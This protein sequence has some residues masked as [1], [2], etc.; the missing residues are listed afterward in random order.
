MNIFANRLQQGHY[1]RE[2]TFGEGLLISQKR[3]VLTDALKCVL[4]EK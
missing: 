4:A 1:L 3:F 2:K